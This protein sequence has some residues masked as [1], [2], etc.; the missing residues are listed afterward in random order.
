[1]DFF[2]IVT[3]NDPNEVWSNLY[4]HIKDVIDSHCPIKLLRIPLDRPSYLTDDIIQIMKARDKEYILARKNTDPLAWARARSL[5]PQ[6]NATKVDSH[7][8]WRIINK[9]FF[10]KNSAK[11]Q[12]V[13]GFDGS[14]FEG[15][16][17]ANELN[18]YFCEISKELSVKFRHESTPVTLLRNLG[19]IVLR[20]SLFV[21]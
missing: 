16:A 21:G 8:F 2:D 19:S 1:M 9:E 18:R 3:S 20:I 17:A 4:G 7:K 15:A 10:Q 5:M 12:Q 11:I 13:L 14:I 6:L